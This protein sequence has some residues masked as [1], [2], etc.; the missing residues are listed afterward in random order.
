MASYLYLTDSQ[1]IT[2]HDYV[3]TI[4]GWLQGVINEGYLSSVTDF[5]QSDI[6]YPEFIDK[7][8]YLLYSI[9]MN[10]CFADA[11]K[12]TAL[13]TTTQFILLNTNDSAIASNFMRTFENIVVL[14][15]D[16]QISKIALTEYIQAF[17]GGYVD[18]E[19][20]LLIIYKDLQSQ[21][22]I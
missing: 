1:I 7:V 8:S 19:S 13:V 2:I 12:R 9:A 17:F 21:H 4:S 22:L 15:A 6:Y 14:V 20:A 18:H 3:L 5:V 10:H 11:N 16:G